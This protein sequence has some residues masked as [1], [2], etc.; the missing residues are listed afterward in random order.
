MVG[1]SCWDPNPE[2]D[3]VL[4]ALDCSRLQ[5]EGLVAYHTLVAD[6]VHL[7]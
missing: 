1:E 6:T 5:V 7:E 3:M 2:D 4:G